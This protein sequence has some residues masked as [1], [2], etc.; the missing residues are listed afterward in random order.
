MNKF[1]CVIIDSGVNLSHPELTDKKIS[2]IHISHDSSNKPIIESDFQDQLGHGTAVYSIIE[3]NAPIHTKIF[4]IKIFDKQEVVDESLL[5]AA[6]DYIALNIECKVVNISL[7]LKLCDDIKSLYLAC[8][9]LFNMGILII[10]AFDNG[11]A[12]SYPAAFDC[13]IGIDATND[14]YSARDY[15]YVEDSPVNI[16]GKGGYQKVA[17]RSPEYAIVQ[18]SSFA[19]AYMTANILNILFDNSE[20]EFERILDLIKN[21]AKK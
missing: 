12:M 20:H 17:W 2:G 4:N 21:K 8:K 10:A 16:L 11:G 13:V 6:L 14:L 5:I 19:C 18:G 7:G 15:T 9:T 1:D 3:K